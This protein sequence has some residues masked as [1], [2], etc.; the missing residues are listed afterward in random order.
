MN[1]IA[2]SNICSII[3]TLFYSIVYLPQFY[4]IYKT[5]SIDGISIYMLLLW[6]Q[7]DLLSLYSTILLELQLNIIVIGWYYVFIG[8]CMVSYVLYFEIKIKITNKQ[9]EIN[10]DNNI[11]INYQNKKYILLIQVLSYYIINF[12]IGIYLTI[13]SI[14]NVYI[15]VIISW[16]TS[17][18]YIIGRIPQIKLN[19]NR[20]STEGLSS[21][22]YI[23]KICGNLFYFFT[24]IIYSTDQKFLLVNLGLFTMIFVTILMDIFVIFQC[25][26]Y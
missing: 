7:A 18:L 15:G 14:S 19:Y 8:L 20:R 17:I 11:I 13:N 6:S 4:E 1:N 10:T 25:I 5:Q 26:F 24:F 9:D 22:M 3:S 2:I 12:T 21:L 23:F 16:M